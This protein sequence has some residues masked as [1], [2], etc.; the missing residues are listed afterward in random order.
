MNSVKIDYDSGR[1]WWAS[2]RFCISKE[3]PGDAGGV[4]TRKALRVAL[5][6][7]TLPRNV[8]KCPQVEWARPCGCLELEKQWTQPGAYGKHGPIQI[9]DSFYSGCK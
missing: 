1:S 4:G 7:R 3:Q 5:L 6:L 2:P 9:A 8:N